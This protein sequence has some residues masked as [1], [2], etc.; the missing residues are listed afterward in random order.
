MK[1]IEAYQIGQPGA[2]ITLYKNLFPSNQ[3]YPQRLEAILTE[4]DP[5]F[6]WN[7]A[8]VGF[9]E[10][11]LDY[12]DCSDFK[13]GGTKGLSLNSSRTLLKSSPTLEKSTTKLWDQFMLAWNIIAKT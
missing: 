8:R 2:C 9:V 12:R 11:M 10:E 6:R 5:F 1:D 13:Y 4:D 3:T 7:N